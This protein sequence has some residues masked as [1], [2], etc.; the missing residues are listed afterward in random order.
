MYCLIQETKS[1]GKPWRT[2]A[3]VGP[4]SRYLERAEAVTRF[5][6]TTGQNFLEN[7]SIDLAVDE[8]CPLCGYARMDG[9]HL[10]QCTG[11]DEYPTDDVVNLNWKA[12]FQILK[13][14]STSF[15]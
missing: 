1:L 8:A 5:H 4:I 9:D 11:L 7:T 6:I 10:S 2:L 12:R 15:G 13:K 14:P 3:T